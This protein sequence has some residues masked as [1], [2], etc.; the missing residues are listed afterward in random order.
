M[1]TTAEPY[2]EV[3]GKLYR[4]WHS[5]DHNRSERRAQQDRGEQHDPRIHHGKKTDNKYRNKDEV[6]VERATLLVIA[7]LFLKTG[8][9]I[10]RI[11]AIKPPPHL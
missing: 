6:T 11:V 10:H 1:N 3:H 9:N 8:R 2:L 7:D 4:H 5:H